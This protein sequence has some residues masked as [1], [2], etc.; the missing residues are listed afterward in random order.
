MFGNRNLNTFTANVFSEGVLVEEMEMR[1]EQGRDP[2]EQKHKRKKSENEGQ[3]WM[4]R[5]RRRK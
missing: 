2:E 5:D 1:V 4:L 3:R